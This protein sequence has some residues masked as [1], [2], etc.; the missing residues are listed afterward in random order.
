MVKNM[1]V[2]KLTPVFLVYAESEKEARAL[3][4]SNIKAW[5]PGSENLPKF[6]CE[7]LPDTRENATIYDHF[8]S[9]GIFNEIF[10]MKKA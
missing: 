3:V 1:T 8:K 10:T 9:M 4:E 6:K 2:Y 7:A 5:V